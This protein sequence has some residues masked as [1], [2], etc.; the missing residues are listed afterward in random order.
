MKN[1]MHSNAKAAVLLIAGCLIT[2]LGLV[3]NYDPSL[4]N[5]DAIEQTSVALNL[6]N[7]NGIRT[8]IVYYDYH[9]LTGQIPATETIFPPGYAVLL[10]FVMTV[11]VPQQYAGVVI[12]SISLL[13]SAFV[14]ADLLKRQGCTAPVSA[15]ITLI[16]LFTSLNWQ[17]AIAGLT[18]PTFVLFTLLSV[19]AV[20]IGL[21]DDQR[22]FLWIFW[23]GVWAA[24][25]FLVRYAGVVFI[26]CI[27][28]YLLF[29][30]ILDRNRK[31]SIVSLIAFAIMPAVVV[32]LTFAR[33]LLLTG[34]LTGGQFIH[35]EQMLM[36]ATVKL[37]YWALIESF[38]LPRSLSASLDEAFILLVSMVL[39]IGVYTK[40]KAFFGD[41][42]Q[43]GQ[44]H[45]FI[46]C[47]SVPIM[48]SLYLCGTTAFLTYS[49]SN[50]TAYFAT[51]RYFLPMLPYALI[52]LAYFTLSTSPTAPAPS[53][54]R[55]ITFVFSVI[56]LL[57]L[58]AGRVTT[59]FGDVQG[60]DP[61][62]RYMEIEFA[63]NQHLSATP[64]I[65]LLHKQSL[66]A[67]LLSNEPHRVYWLTNQPTIGLASG[68]YSTTQW[69][70]ERVNQLARQYGIKYIIFFPRL[71]A[72]R[73]YDS[74]WNENQH[75]F[76]DLVQGQIPSFVRVVV[77]L[78]EIYVYETTF[79]KF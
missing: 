79:S 1:M 47:N 72:A 48:S 65:E 35:A 40:G 49:I 46:A 11:G 59:H 57:V 9:Y 68:W 43:S 41:R 64:I 37:I 7:G 71:F 32:A 22:R 25:A 76:R 58:I 38:D 31:R 18:E 6:L 20:H 33:N 30:S 13:L 39:A 24:A 77:S 17:V 78:P 26:A 27:G 8:S 19:R 73:S 16:W 3:W 14:L 42:R 45:I 66:D 56:I 75:F 60:W 62:R 2:I 4:I 70:S 74:Q 52:V 34:D 61:D 53:I 63:L 29:Y 67:P 21:I 50:V 44:A 10:A 55:K 54:Q 12:A 36:L 5:P 23:S 69:T 51:P 15:G 28:A